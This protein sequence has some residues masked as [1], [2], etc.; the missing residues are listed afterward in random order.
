MESAVPPRKPVLVFPASA[1]HP[2][3]LVGLG[4]LLLWQGWLTLQLFGAEHSPEP[5]RNGLPIISGRHALHLYHGYLGARTL[6]QRGSPS[7]YDPAFHAGYP[8]TPIFDGGSRPAE[9]ILAL[10]GG[11]YRPQAYKIGLGLLCLLVPGV[12]WLTARSLLLPRSRAFLA[13]LLG[14]LLWWSPPLRDALEAGDA[15]VLLG[16]LML[17]AE[18]GFLIRFHQSKDLVSILGLVIAGCLGWLASPLL[19]VLLVPLLLV[20]YLSVGPRH[21]LVWHGILLAALLLGFAVNLFWLLDWL[22]YWWIRAPLCLDASWAPPSRWS[23][24]WRAALWGDAFERFWTAVL[25]GTAALGVLLWQRHGQRPAARVVG[26]GLAGLLL[27]TVLGLVWEPLAR[28]DSTRLLTPTL[29]L[30]IFPAAHGVPILLRGTSRL[31]SSF[32]PRFLLASAVAAASWLV[33]EQVR[34]WVERLYQTRPLRIGLGHEREALVASLR[35]HTTNEARILWEDWSLERTDPHWTALLP[36]LTGR[37]FVGGLDALA[38]IEHTVGG[39]VDQVLA[40]RPVREWTDAQLLDYCE[41]Y[42]IGWVAAWS[43]PTVDRFLSWPAAEPIQA[44]HNQCATGCLFRI[45]RRPSF[46]VTGMAQVL[47]ADTQRIVLG[48][49]VPYKGRVVL[50]LHYQAGMRVTPGRVQIEGDQNSPDAIPFVRLLLN[51]PAARVTITWE[52]K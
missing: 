13:G 48:D 32:L 37:S 26:L 39:L 52:M 8:K 42:N 33:P 38:G 49:V 40:G 7:C 17:A 6:L 24:L 21:R 44:L 46:A 15:D 23:A 10:A 28:L 19:Q 34:G 35:A 12:V 3:W 18:A 51:E 43:S 31:G 36:Y 29:L 4:A 16:G 27:L 5:F 20:Y 47:H 25:L 22:D 45:R 1:E 11:Q 14:V 41:R 2:L 50:S 9:L 30:A